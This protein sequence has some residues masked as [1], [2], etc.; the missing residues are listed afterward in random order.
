MGVFG[1]LFSP[2][3]VQV[4]GQFS[5]ASPYMYRR[6]QEAHH[7]ET[8]GTFCIFLPQI[9]SIRKGADAMSI[10]FYSSRDRGLLGIPPSFWHRVSSACWLVSQRIGLKVELRS[11]RVLQF[12]SYAS[13]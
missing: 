5:R 3:P 6:R 9:E 12:Y 2:S 8:R 11:V 1:K 4:Q 7:A 10:H 13:C